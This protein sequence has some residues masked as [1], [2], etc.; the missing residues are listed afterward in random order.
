MD[1]YPS[2]L[3]IKKNWHKYTLLAV[4]LIGVMLLSACSSPTPV[5]TP[6]ALPPTST[7][8]PPTAVP[9]IPVE[10]LYE[11][12]WVLV[13]YGDPAN[14]TVVPQGLQITTEFTPDGQLSGHGGCNNYQGSF[15]ASPDGTL[16]VGPLATTFMFCEQSMEQETAYL[17][18]LQ[19]ATGFNFSNEGRLLVSYADESDQEQQLTFIQGQVSL[20]DVTWVL[21]SFGDPDSPQQ[22]PPGV[23]ITANFSTDGQLSGNSGCNSYFADFTIQE[24]QI[25]I[26][27]PGSTMMACPIGMEEEAAFLAALEQAQ[28]YSITGRDLSITYDNGIGVLNFSSA[29][30]PF[31]Y[32][33]WTLVSMDSQPLG[34]DVEITASFTPGEDPAQGSVAGSA[35]CNRYTA[36]YT[37]EGANLTIEMPAT[38]L[39]MCPEE[40]MDAETA[41][42]QA[43]Q[44]ASSYQILGDNLVL[45]TENGTLTFSANRTPLEG[46]LWSLI[47]LG[48]VNEPQN[49]VSGSNFTA[50][51][52]RNPQSPSGVLAGTTGCNEYAAAYAASLEEIKINPP[53]ST[54]NTSCVPGLTDQEQLYY[55][56]LNDATTYR[57]SGNT[58]TI[59]YDQD[60]QA[61]VFQG[62]QLELGRLPLS[63]L[64]NSQW[65]LWYINNQPILPGTS[66]NA[67]FT[68]NPDSASGKMNGNAGCNSY[69]AVFG[70]DL[71]MQTNL[72]S[73][74]FCGSPA[75]M[76]E[77]E[78]AY[79]Q[80]L[81]R[82][83]GFWL[84]GDQ[85]II[86]T[87]QG[88]LT[89]RSMLPP[90]SSDQTHLLVSRNWY[91]VSYNNIYSVPGNQEPFT[92]FDPNGTL[93]GFT[94]CNNLTGNFQTDI[95]QISISALSTTLTSCTDRA[96]QAQEQAVLDILGSARTYQVADTVMQ[97]VGDQGVL[98]YSLLPINRP[99]EIQ[100]PQAIINAPSQAQVG[101][102]VTF[103]A[104]AST[105]QV[106]IINYQW[107]FGDGV[108]GTGA[109]VQHVYSAP[110][111][112]RVQMTVTDR[113]NYRGSS[114][115][116]IQITQIEPPTPQPTQAP[117][118]TPTP[119]PTGQPPQ[120]TPTS[121]PPVE[122]LP[123]QA[124][125][126]G[127]NQV[128]LGEPVTFDASASTPGSNPIASFSWNFG[129]GTTAG[130]S[131]DPTQTTL[132]NQTGRY[133]VS[134][135]V[136][137]A[138]G[139]S[140]S[141]TIEVAVSTRLDTPIAWTLESL[142]NQPLLAGTAIT[143][144]FLQGN[145]A[146][147]S[148]CNSYNG[149]YD[150]TLNED[151]SYT[152]TISD[153]VTS[154]QACP[155]E[156]MRQEEYYLTF[157]R[158]ITAAQLQQNRLTTAYPAGTGPDGR[159]Y[160]DGTLT[161]LQIGTP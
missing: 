26:T 159:P 91:L 7:V 11:T 15:Q 9:E 138:D 22:L 29:E 129:D 153:L 16:T 78:Q 90:Q 135:V 109:V 88:A 132:F 23:I 82:S 73:N 97:I 118:E 32:T 59:P 99:A 98:N 13:G 106:P 116:N 140:S 34:E 105:G 84:T 104:S 121:E 52:M 80:A 60:R 156:I 42:L 27:Q 1:S 8:V 20:T 12:L 148:G 30:Y 67:R 17:T 10:Q 115:L 36:G 70:E 38:T 6:T 113:R 126:Q 158:S 112:Y 5:E 33:L 57:I 71:G 133:Q 64:D 77:Q 160:P 139:L 62:T 68:I 89:Y 51:F 72:S 48:D 122:V 66:I 40:I 142:Q 127:P 85:L 45:T 102:V 107:D 154:K 58:L 94:G 50:Q 53:V 31:E 3:L 92:F 81:S 21:V 161:F 130:P 4:L 111:T 24:D 56:A 74:Q 35:G 134:V 108:R 43:L 37:R 2:T 93:A 150:A 44:S 55:L 63:D 149:R 28:Q 86:N 47:A 124:V 65:F 131:T 14:P 100:P 137:D 136:A 146:G 87:G 110:G 157:L 128:F 144:Q 114:A 147:F 69:E 125:I 41:F 152:V 61:L 18:A 145:V 83:Y 123:P 101:Q 151:G 75:G 76:M 155:E 120:P 39:M 103:D 19:N 54:Q 95:N 143:L 25:T 119:E 46:A 79:L 96:L 49:P 117:Q 141:A